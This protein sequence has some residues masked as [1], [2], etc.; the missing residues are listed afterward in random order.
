MYKK[1]LRN[2]FL[3]RLHAYKPIARPPHS[4][5]ILRGVGGRMH[6]GICPK[7]GGPLE[8]ASVKRIRS[9]VTRPNGVVGA[10]IAGRMRFDLIWCVAVQH[11]VMFSL[12]SNV[13]KKCFCAG[14]MRHVAWMAG[15]RIAWIRLWLRNASRSFSL[16]M[17]RT[18]STGHLAGGRS[19]VDSS[20]CLCV[21]T[22]RICPNGI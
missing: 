11:P 7:E 13:G 14:V 18:I 22:K 21:G 10:E 12:V 9:G 6:G 19:D 16:A 4:S 5:A 8:V 17:M 3:G 2:L 15:A 1:Q 20:D